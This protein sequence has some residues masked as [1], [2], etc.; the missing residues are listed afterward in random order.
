MA[1]A[2]RTD[3]VLTDADFQ[4]E[5]SGSQV[6]TDADFQ[7]SDGQ[8]SATAQPQQRS[9]Y[10]SDKGISVAHPDTMSDEDVQNSIWDNYYT[11]PVKTPGYIGDIMQADKRADQP[12]G[13]AIQGP[14]QKP[15]T[16]GEQVAYPFQRLFSQGLEKPSWALTEGILRSLVSTKGASAGLAGVAVYKFAEQMDV[17]AK[18]ANDL[19]DHA[20]GFLDRAIDYFSQPEKYGVVTPP[21]EAMRGRLREMNYERNYLL[22]IAGDTTEAITDFMAFMVTAELSGAGAIGKGASAA[23]DETFLAGFAKSSAK[24]STLALFTTR[25]DLT[26]RAKAAVYMIAYNMTPYIA[27][28][29]GATGLTAAAVN[30]ALNAFLSSPQYLKA[31]R[32]AGGINRESAALIIPQF[33]MDFGFA[34]NTRGTPENQMKAKVAKYAKQRAKELNLP[35]DEAEMLIKAIQNAILNPPA[36]P[37][38]NPEVAGIRIEGPQQPQKPTQEARQQAIDEILALESSGAPEGGQM[39]KAAKEKAVKDG[40][41][42]AIE[43][44]TLM[45]EEA[46]AT[47]REGRVGEL[48]K[49]QENILD[50]IDA[51]EAKRRE[52]VG[53]SFSDEQ[54]QEKVAEKFKRQKD[55]EDEIFEKRR[56]REK[57]KGAEK[58]SEIQDSIN[59]LKAE[60]AETKRAIREIESLKQKPATTK[61]LEKLDAKLDELT[62]Q[63]DEMDAQMAE[64]LQP[65]GEL[66]VKDSQMVRL[67][68][69]QVIRTAKQSFSQG[70]KAGTAAEKEQQKVRDAENQA[71]QK[72]RLQDVKTAQ[73]AALEI[74]ES[75]G[76]T[77]ADRARFM[78]QIKNIQSVEDFLKVS[79]ELE[80]KALVM[81]EKTSKRILQRR[82]KK[83]LQKTTV[84]KEGGKPTSRFGAD[85]QK[86]LDGARTASRMRTEAALKKIQANVDKINDL[87][88]QNADASETYPLALENRILQAVA[89]AENVSSAQLADILDTVRELK[90][91]GRASTKL[92]NHLREKA[93]D[94]KIR[95]YVDA[96]SGGAGQPPKRT[97]S[98]PADALDTPAG[99]VKKFFRSVIFGWNDLMDV[100]SQKDKKSKAGQSFI[101]KD[102]DVFDQQQAQKNLVREFNN[103]AQEAIQNSYGLKSK[104]ETDAKLREMQ[105]PQE[106]GTFKRSDGVTEE[107]IMTRDQA[108][109][110]WMEYQ[111]PTL[112]ATFESPEGMAW[113]PEMLN[114]VDKFLTKEDKAFGQAQFEIYKKI[115]PLANDVYSKMYGV[116]LPF[117]EFYS[118]IRRF[119][120][121][122]DVTA[123]FGEM[124]QEIKTRAGIRPASTISRVNNE[125]PLS[126]IGSMSAMQRHIAEM[127][128]FVAW[129][130]KVREM[131]SIFFSD[132]VQKTIVENYGKGT[133]QIINGFID[134]FTANGSYKAHRAG[135]MGDFMDAWR[136]KFTRAKTGLRPSISVKQLTGFLA[137]SETVPAKDFA[138]GLVKFWADPVKN[139]KT[140]TESDF[141]KTRW[142]SI[143]RDIADALKSDSYKAFRKDPSFWN[144]LMLNVQLGDKAAIVMGGWPL[145]NHLRSKGI[146]H[147][148]ALREFSKIAN[149][150]QQSGD[151]AELSEFQRGGPLAKLFTMFMSSPNQY[152]RREMFAVRNMMSGRISTA[153]AAKTIALY[154]FV[155]PMF[156]Q[157]VADLGFKPKHQARAAIMGSMNGIFIVSDFV[158]AMINKAFGEKTYDN[159]LPMYSIGGSVSD[160]VNKTV[161]AFQEGIDLEEAIHGL[162]SLLD[163]GDHVT[164]A[165]LQEGAKMIESLWKI[166][167]EDWK[168]AIFGAL[169][170]PDSAL[171]DDEDSSVL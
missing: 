56:E 65:E 157:M 16:M 67:K 34:W 165:P 104:K 150:T 17:D 59:K 153:Q 111:D 70:V 152:L 94:E 168:G 127:S 139:M 76:L 41:L 23:M 22:G 53:D 167:E 13:V 95:R 39:V 164:G 138:A 97:A 101:S 26:D 134:D 31:I 166:Y 142:E 80:R 128:H 122:R 115:Y 71:A 12:A 133:A 137:F 86:I 4:D 33:I 96:I 75:A 19:K 126:L 50:E 78:R 2:T 171:K 149:R 170:W 136:V 28:A 159:E 106:L 38:V 42:T 90:A 141:L 161:K 8:Q 105:E 146:S 163:I 40:I 84:K 6:L 51:L 117:N 64:L 116:N 83:E 69:S 125:N 93:I 156:F 120:F 98:Q 72:E 154:H 29:T 129:A 121:K 61:A 169:G 30:G 130:E 48:A 109:K 148:E 1:D 15:V 143:D 52:V 145:Y 85:V 21:A 151:L 74:V 144:A 77:A 9:T 35:P 162:N 7:E 112:K 18:M 57:A 102:A 140:L 147:E 132:E 131:R 24:L 113:T 82:L 160:V 54:I 44:E 14:E 158:E 73:E 103:L 68:A 49:K 124:M 110:K 20:P 62:E 43:A 119:D 135:A 99:A 63:Y 108:I 66:P 46:A 45:T 118:P 89:D 81:S 114:A 123:G 27:N 47:V 92:E 10:L 37:D 5:P 88:S 60:L 58:K 11:I 36:T 87:I 25:G 91:V 55:I 107:M 3:Q 155:M 79:E 100:I 32:E